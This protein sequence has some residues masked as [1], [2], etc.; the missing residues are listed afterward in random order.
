MCAYGGAD[1]ARQAALVTTASRIKAVASFVERT[2]GPEAKQ[3]LLADLGLAPETLADET[4][5]IASST[6]LVAL[7]WLA[8]REGEE[9]LL[10][11]GEDLLHDENLGVFAPLLHAHE[12]LEDALGQLH[13]S[14]PRLGLLP[15]EAFCVE[16]GRCLLRFRPLGIEGERLLRLADAAVLLALCRLYGFEDAQVELRDDALLV[17][18]RSH[19]FERW[20]L[21]LLP[22]LG[23]FAFS[24]RTGIVVTLT[25][26]AALVFFLRERAHR[27]ES[28]AQ[29]HRIR[30]LE[31]GLS[32][33]RRPPHALVEG[34][35]FAGA[36]RL[37]PLLGIGANGAVHRALRIADGTP[38]AI[39]LLRHAASHDALAADRLHREAEAL[40]LSRHPNVV[41]LYE[42]GLVDGV[43]YL[44]L[45][46]LD[47][48]EPLSEL[49]ARKGPL[50]PEALLPLALEI[51]DALVAIHAAGVV[52]RDIKP[53][54]V[55]V[56]SRDGAP[57]I[58]LFDFGLAHIEWAETRLTEPGRPLGTPGYRAPELA[59]GRTADARSDIYAFGIL[60]KECLT[61]QRPT[62]N[63]SEVPSVTRRASGIERTAH[64]LPPGFREVIDQATAHDPRDRFPD[65]KSLRRALLSMEPSLLRIAR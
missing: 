20:A 37:G 57:T 19:R 28:R 25:T 60:L 48:G 65:A 39:K 64:P 29:R 45:E 7:A 54:N 8:S 58:K 3:H 35:V 14:A 9:A 42:H 16:A 15:I 59:E 31:R 26:V 43:A 40:L 49:L 5:T 46:L 38:V 51:C 17:R 22:S 13:R 23:T 24:A 52:H 44:A 18:F 2:R 55:F 62:E 11:L 10:G 61:G 36:Y 50:S 1:M 30:V 6:H 4:R 53:S 21:A 47:E 41:E 56:G 32:L 33:S 63:E 34:E 27:I 12:R